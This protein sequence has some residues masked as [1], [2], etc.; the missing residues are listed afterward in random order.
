[1]NLHEMYYEECKAVSNMMTRLYNTR[2]TTTSGGNISLR[3]NEELFCISPSGLDKSCLNPEDIA[4]VTL[5][6]KNL[7]P[8][9]PLSI[10][11]EMHRKLLISRSD[12]NAVVHAHPC[13]STLFST[14]E[15]FR[16]NTALVAESYFLIGEPVMIPYRRMGTEELA[17]VVCES[18]KKNNVG[19]LANHGII[20]LGKTLVKAFDLIEVLENSSKMTLATEL[21]S[22]KVKSHSLDQ[23]QKQELLDMKNG[24]K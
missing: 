16:I 21:L 8:D 5:D 3:L 17:D 9:L 4:I 22:S 14:F 19:I 11:S 10:E 18:L 7:T 20:T 23:Q 1:M 15:N 12:I 2:L 6:G 24:K 13:W